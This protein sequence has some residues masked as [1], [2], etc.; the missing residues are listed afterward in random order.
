MGTIPRDQITIVITVIFTFHKYFS[1]PLQISYSSLLAFH[2]C[3]RWW[4]FI[5]VC[6]TPSPFKF[7]GFFSV[8]YP[9]S[10]MLWLRWF[11]LSSDFH[12]IQFPYQVFSEDNSV[13]PSPSCS[14]HFLLSGSRSEYLLIFL[15]SLVFP[16]WF[17]GNRIPLFSKFCP[18][19]YIY[20]SIPWSGVVVRIIW[21]VCI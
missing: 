5:W 11:R 4:T 7:P 14:I 15:F 12:F 17:T 2:T 19:F 9:T 8:S 6:V 10:I 20:R 18:L 21:S 3:I 16:M 1:C 13:F